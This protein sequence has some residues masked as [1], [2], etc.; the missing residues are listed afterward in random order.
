MFRSFLLL[1]G[2]AFPLLAQNPIDLSDFEK[3]A[4]EVAIVSLDQS[5]LR[6]LEAFVPE[7]GE[8]AELF[9]ALKGANS[10]R[11]RALSF[12]DRT[13]PSRS[14]FDSLRDRVS[15][16]GWKEFLETQS[17]DNNENVSGFLG[18]EGL[19]I[20][21]GEAG[22][23]TSVE[24]KGSVGAGQA[25]LFGGHFGLP[26]LHPSKALPAAETVPTDTAPLRR[27]AKLDFHQV[28]R[29][30]EQREG[31]KRV[32]I[33][34]LGLAAPAA[35][36]GS[37][38]RVRGV[39]LAIFENAPN[40]FTDSVAKAVPRDWARLVEVRGRGEETYVFIGEAGTRMSLLVATHDSEDGVLVTAKIKARD[41][42]QPALA[43]GEHK[44]G[45]E[46]KDF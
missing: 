39:D 22:E 38:G 8:D 21:A 26:A 43:W 25:V 15:R 3:Q 18:P 7:E 20:I 24:V 14:D 46:S 16:A 6:A 32:H 36:I 1:A 19:L 2:A 34:F 12:E 33:P 30:V 28:V 31:I 45:G 10:I 5:T 13:I 29:A 9:R 35:F 27:P 23:L 40:S 42:C 11:V 37:G 44:R 4:D 41:L 17:K